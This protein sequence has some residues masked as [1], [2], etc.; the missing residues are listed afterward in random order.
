MLIIDPREE[1]AIYRAW[2]TKAEKRLRDMFHDIC[3]KDASTH[4]LTDEILQ[5]LKAA[6]KEKQVKAW[7]SRGSTCGGSLHTGSSTTIE[8]RGSG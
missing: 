2:R 7:T 4:W 8:A 6:F 3:V 5:A 1:A